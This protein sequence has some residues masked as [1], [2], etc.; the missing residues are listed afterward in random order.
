MIAFV[1]GERA[2][3]SCVTS[4][5]YEPNCTS[6]KT[7][8]QPN[9]TIGFTVVGKPAATVITSSPGLIALSPNLGEVSV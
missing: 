6:T 9:C 8:M 5:L 4:I 7:G 1:F 3:S 2:A